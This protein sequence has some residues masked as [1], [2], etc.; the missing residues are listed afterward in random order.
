MRA[1]S[2]VKDQSERKQENPIKTGVMLFPIALVLI[3]AAPFWLLIFLRGIYLRVR[4]HNVA[5][6]QDKF[7]IFVYSN[8]PK[9][10]SY[11][12]ENILPQIQD[13]TIVLNWSERDQWKKAD[14]TVQSFHHWGGQENFNPLAIV[15]CNLFD[16]RII[17]FYKAFRDLKHG[18]VISL[19][20]AEAQLFDLLKVV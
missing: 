9:W 15:F 18:K 19:Q 20:K 12:E 6:T 11:I 5:V 10:K 17:R 4:F 14:W 2:E 3:V 13:H 8:S 7:I 16:V 1:F